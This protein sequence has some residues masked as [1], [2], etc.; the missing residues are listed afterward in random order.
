[1]VALDTGFF[2][3]MM[4][5]NSEAIAL[6]RWLKQN[7]LRPVISAI[8]AGELLY[9]LYREKKKEEA[10]GIVERIFRIADAIPVDIEVAK[11][12][13]G[14]KHSQGMPYVDAL[15]GA[16]ALSSGCQKLYTSDRNHM[17]S[18]K[19]Y[20]LEIIIIREEKRP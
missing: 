2:I 16:T 7:R 15:I 9:V 18:L 5:G 1:M 11:K 13:A 6:W 20:G 8:T 12:G 19:S 3:A 17:K 14:I 10:E 4:R